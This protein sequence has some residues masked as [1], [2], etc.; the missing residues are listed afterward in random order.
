MY[1]QTIGRPVESGEGGT[2]I[3]LPTLGPIP[4]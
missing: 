4:A 1:G 2:A 3:S